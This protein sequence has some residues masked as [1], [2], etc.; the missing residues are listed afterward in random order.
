ME[1]LWIKWLESSW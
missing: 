1:I